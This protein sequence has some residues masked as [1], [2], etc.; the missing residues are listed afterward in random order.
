MA[1]SSIQ[2][3]N[4]LMELFCGSIAGPSV[5]K[6]LLPFLLILL[7]SIDGTSQ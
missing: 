5:C 6:S 7:L 4:F 2:A 3:I 1:A